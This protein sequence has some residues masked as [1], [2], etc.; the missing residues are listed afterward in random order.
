M[1]RIRQASGLGLALLL[2]AFPMLITFPNSC[3]GKGTKLTR[4]LAREK[5]AQVLDCPI[6]LLLPGGKIIDHFKLDMP[7]PS[8]RAAR[9]SAEVLKGLERQSKIIK[10]LTS[11]A[12]EGFI[13]F[14]FS[15]PQILF[16]SKARTQPLHATYEIKLALTERGKEF[17]MSD[18][19]GELPF[20][21]S[22]KYF[23]LSPVHERALTEEFE[24]EFGVFCLKLCEKVVHQVTRVRKTGKRSVAVDFEWKFDRFTSLGEF[25]GRDFDWTFHE[26]FFAVMALQKGNPS[27]VVDLLDGK[28][29]SRDSARFIRDGENWRLELGKNP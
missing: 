6:V 3:R 14:S 12:D 24:G 8:L 16:D 22:L 2:V 7:M 18:L 27:R 20:S 10:L 1:K 23:L 17:L 11:M 26:G 28:T 13:S 25:I 19:E 4:E 9:E 5:L 21:L 29:S 15:G